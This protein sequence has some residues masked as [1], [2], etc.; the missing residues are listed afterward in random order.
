MLCQSE[1]RPFL[2]RCG[3]SFLL[4][5][6]ETP[7]SQAVATMPYVVALVG[8]R[9]LAVSSKQVR[10]IVILE[11][12]NPLPRTPDW[13]RGVIN[14]RGQ[15][16]RLID[17]RLWLGYT[18]AEKEAA[19][20]CALLTAREED[21]R[22]WLNELE[23]CLREERAFTKAR[24]PHQCA[25]GKWYDQYEPKNL[26]EDMVM[27]RF[28]EPHERIHALADELLGRASRGD[29]DGALEAIARAREGVLAEM[30]RHF[31]EAREIFANSRRELALVLEYEGQR[32]AASVDE[33]MTVEQIADSQWEE[34]PDMLGTGSH[35]HWDKVGRLKDGQTVVM[36]VRPESFFHALRQAGVPEKPQVPAEAMAGAVE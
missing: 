1:W 4:L 7:M 8:G 10:E 9:A 36:R 19:E 22:N 14:L 2:F 32:V 21:H 24:D 26:L 31:A 13:V 17:W 12:C 3:F 20:L 25:F 29:R 33:V 34:V 18:S 28:E 5:P 16:L 23:A 11:K 30:L 27:K 15:I 6:P 35:A